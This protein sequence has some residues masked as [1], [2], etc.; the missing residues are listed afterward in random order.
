MT[1]IAAWTAEIAMDPSAEIAIDP[2][3]DRVINGT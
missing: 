1:N 3:A 2:S